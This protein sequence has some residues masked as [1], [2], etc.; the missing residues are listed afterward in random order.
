RNFMNFHVLSLF[1]EYFETFLKNGVVGG[2]VQKKLISLSVVNPRDFTEGNYKM[3]DDIPYGGGDGMVMAFEPMS[4]AIQS[5]KSENPLKIY[6]SP[7]GEPLTDKVAKTMAETKRDIVFIC[8][9]YAGVD[10]RFISEYVDQEISVGNYVVSGGELPAL[11]CI[12]AI[13]RHV[14]GVLGN[15]DSAV[16]DSFHDSLLEAPSFTRPAEIDGLGVPKVLTEGHHEKIATWKRLIS[17]LRT[18]QRRPDL[19]ERANISPKERLLA[20]KL[21]AEMSEK[22]LRISGLKNQALPLDQS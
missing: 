18:F 6:L 13:A 21:L 19:Y 2:A 1:P 14:P 15:K 7:Q 5:I 16:K 12:D 20:N 9:R 11:I 17:I 22:D 4:K 10:E 3:V 8:G